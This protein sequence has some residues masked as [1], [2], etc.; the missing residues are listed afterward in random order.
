MDIRER[1]IV[2][3]INMMLSVGVRNTTMDAVANSLRISKRTIYEHFTDKRSLIRSCIDQMVDQ[4]ERQRLLIIEQSTDII[5]ELG[6]MLKHLQANFDKNGRLP[7]EIQLNYPDIYN[8]VYV[9][10][11]ARSYANMV[12]Q[13][14]RGIEQGLIMASTNVNF[15]SYILLESLNSMMT[16]H[17][18]YTIPVEIKPIEAFKYVLLHFFRGISTTEGIKRIDAFIEE[19]HLI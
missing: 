18:K 1:I 4:Q 6:S 12:E 7:Q 13:L 14:K 17:N 8:Q 9:E 19:R 11:H 2:A 5:D 10:H 16:N 3:A 15:S